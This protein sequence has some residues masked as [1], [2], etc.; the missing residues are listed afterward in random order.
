MLV[1]VALS[2]RHE[3]SRPDAGRA[4]LALNHHYPYE[5]RVYTDTLYSPLHC[6]L[7]LNI[8]DLRCIPLEDRRVARDARRLFMPLSRWAG[9]IAVVRRANTHDRMR[10]GHGPWQEGLY[11]P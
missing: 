4:Q 9:L 11:M 5:S 1:A 8:P 7:Y 2:R 10:Q 3:H 6:P